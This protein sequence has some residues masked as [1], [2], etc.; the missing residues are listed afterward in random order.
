MTRRQWTGLAG[1]LFAAAFLA[2][3]FTS[4]TTPDSDGSGAIDRY[5]EYW[6]DSDNQDRAFYGVLIMT[7]GS[8]LL[9]WFAAGLRA[10]LRGVDSGSA[11]L[12][13]SAGAASGALFGVGVVMVNGPGVA[14]A[15][16]GIEVD[17]GTAILLEEMGYPVMAL[18][19]MM[20]GAMAVAFSVANRRAGVVP[21]WTAV[22]TGLLALAALGSVFTAWIGF[23][24]LPLWCA[25]VGVVLLA[26]RGAEEPA[27][28]T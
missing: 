7:Y 6:R 4:G 17:G 23:M 5:A 9:V 11:G 13:R 18:G 15:D 14:G 21:Q 27:A 25:V 2:A 16:S 28:A 12:V 10:L 22:V 19:V 26:T 24:V 8:V 20:A 1:V 3:M